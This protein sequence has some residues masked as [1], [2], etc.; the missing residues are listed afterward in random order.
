MSALECYTKTTLH[1]AIT[2]FITSLSLAHKLAILNQQKLAISFA[3]ESYGSLE[4]TLL[5]PATIEDIKDALDQ[6]S[7]GDTVT[8]ATLPHYWSKVGADEW[9]VRMVC[10]ENESWDDFP[11]D[12]YLD[13]EDSMYFDSVMAMADDCERE[14]EFESENQQE[15]SAESLPVFERIR[16]PVKSNH[17]WQKQD[18][19]KKTLR[20]R[21]AV[22]LDYTQG[23]DE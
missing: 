23:S 12:P 4:F 15:D 22:P 20:D 1:K 6:C 3:Q 16:K 10:L 19:R 21:R 17:K 14:F 18:R 13:Q 11:F 9:V 5:P 7:N 2:M 8:A